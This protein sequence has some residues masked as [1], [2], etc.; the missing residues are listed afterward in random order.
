M[1]TVS[2]WL[3]LTP[4]TRENG[5]LEVIPGSHRRPVPPEPTKDARYSIG[6]GGL[7]ADPAYFREADKVALPM[8]AG[9]FLL[10]NERLL[11]H[12]EPNRT[13][14]RRLG[15]GIRLTLPLVKVYETFPCLMVSGQDAF[16]F[17]RLARPPEE[18]PDESE[19]WTAL[20]H[21]SAVTLDTPVPGLG[22]FPPET[23]G[24]RTFCWSGPGGE[25]WL[26]LRL[27][28]PGER[29]F[30]CEI[31]HVLDP[32]VLEELEVQVNGQSLAFRQ[33]ADGPGVRLEGS[34]PASMLA[35]SPSRARVTFRVRRMLR[36]C[37]LDPASP[38]ARPLGIAVSR[39]SLDPVE[40]GTP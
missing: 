17:N 31:A 9:E 40:R 7:R 18:E 38:D 5:C 24:A 39:V 14:D 12:S 16:G 32:R 21:G 26:D 4:A 8:D 13:R 36:P 3:A 27:A 35:G 34:V 37:D 15:L 29:V 10:F 20:P 6:F 19:W 2:A 11:H 1:V 25:S 33:H 28:G 22:W 30:R 23:D